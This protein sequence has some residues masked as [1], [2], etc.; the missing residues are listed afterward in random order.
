MRL[1]STPAH[2][3]TPEKEWFFTAAPFTDPGKCSSITEDNSYQEKNIEVASKLAEKLVK[4][5]I[6][7]NN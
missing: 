2:Q 3:G 4:V 7:R 5:P 1:S 6:A